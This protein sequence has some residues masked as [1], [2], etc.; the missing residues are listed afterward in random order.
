MERIGGCR[1]IYDNHHKVI[2]AKF[3][4]TTSNNVQKMHV[5]GGVY[6]AKYYNILMIIPTE[7]ARIT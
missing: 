6:S 4:H 2:C 7:I 3:A 1:K 5:F